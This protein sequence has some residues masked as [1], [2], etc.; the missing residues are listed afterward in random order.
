MGIE[1]RILTCVLFVLMAFS[2]QRKVHVWLIGDSTIADKEVKAYP[3]T[4]WGM[5]FAHFF[6]GE[7]VVDNRAKNGRSTG[8]FLREGLWQPVVEGLGT[9]D[10]VFIQ[11]GHNDEVKTKASYTTPEEFTGNLQRYIDDVRKKGAI[12]VLLTP[13]ARRKFDSLGLI[14]E[15]HPVYA[16]L[17][18][19]VAVRNKVV[20]ID[21]A[22]TSKAFLQQYG[23]EYSRVLFNYL[24]PGEH[25]NYPEGRKDDTHFSE[26]GA[27]KMA[28]LVAVG[29][30]GL[31]LGL[32]E[33]LV[34]V[35][36]AAGL[37]MTVAADGSGDYL[38][39]QAAL[40]AVPLNNVK[41]V[42]I[43]IRRGVYREKLRLDS[44]KN[45][46]TLLGEDEWNTIL[47][48]DDHP[49][50]RLLT[51]DSVN[52][53]NSHSFLVK[54]DDFT[55][56]RLTIRNDAGFSAGQAVALEVQGDRAR[57]EEC[58]IVGNQDVLFL[59]SARSRVCFRYCDIEGTTDFIFGDATAW[60]DHCH[61]HSK[62]DS[63]VTAA[64]TP[65]DHP[66][67]FVFYDCIL[68]GDTSIHHASL[69]R[70]WRP[71]ASVDYIRCYIGAHIRPEG[72]SDWNNN[73]SYKTAR[74][75]EYRDYGP[76]A[77]TAA[78][79]PWV[80]Q[81]TDEEAGRVGVRAV[82]GGWEPVG[83]ATAN[84]EDYSWDHLPVISEPVFR[85]DTFSIVR[86]GAVQDPLRL[87]T[88]AINDAIADC[89]RKG[90]GVV[91]V[92]A[93]YWLTGPLVLRSGVNLHIDRAA[94]LQFTADL[95]QYPLVEGNW[96]G[97]PAARCQSPIS[98]TDL[99]NIAITGGGIIDASGDAWR[100]LAKD[101]LPEGEWNKKV[102]AGGVLSEDGKTWYPS[103]KSLKG[104][105]AKDAGVLRPGMT[106]S[107]F[108]DIKDFLRPNL[109]VL[110]RCKKVLLEGTS[111]Q[112]SPAWCLHTLLCEDLTL[113]D[114]HVRNPWYAA[115]GDGV[116]L[117]SC[118]NVLVENSTFDAGD[119]GICI[120]SGRDEEGRKRGKPTENV[121][122]RNDIVYR[123][124]GG[125]V[126]GSEMS[127]GARNIFVSDC[128][129]I[130][131]DIGLR[132][133]TV[134]GRGG[135]VEKIWVRNISMR[136]IV[137]QAVFLDMYYFARAPAPGE[138]VAAAPPVTE[139]TPSFRNIHISNIV[140]D[141]AEEG[142]F[143]RGLP[144]MRI[145]DIYMENMVL[146]ADK[147]MEVS[148]GENIYLKDIK[149]I[150]KAG[151]EEINKKL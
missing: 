116:D 135:V 143:V 62:K 88:G 110:T 54:A 20:L 66:Y 115:N 105:H 25:P 26:W 11:F 69:G 28:E 127:G 83:E 140:C 17:V 49:G 68:T 114:V 122:I 141:G 150:T 86:Y 104:A 65:A 44:S 113:R 53:R 8:T 5:P 34:L 63:H 56:R 119:D 23:P 9:G 3:E 67:G 59:N 93:G 130:G 107:S 40:D 108:A 137:H 41:P 125:F 123:G 102:A 18:R 64:S 6:D 16:Q 58:R 99:E 78:R 10:Y 48:Y 90:G 35:R 7:V 55:A 151:T 27:M 121:I 100:M 96:E 128:S 38:T 80:H 89:S 148:E 82:L 75:G 29:I 98:G 2:P 81:L 146:K 19:D 73:G 149:L 139:G 131:T 103:E 45:F 51:G 136:N 97:H 70:P 87:N 39:V 15:T 74:Y 106:L 12:P 37:V 57:I 46:V 61:I 42:T 22:E 132:F 112:N 147:G 24:Q 124:H 36:P 60:F 134:R 85:Q 31:K 133:K 109:L 145:R 21:L 33:H 117:E 120:K 50:M 72:W 94:I 76:G 13:V 111:F 129:F 144:E 126:V 91:L 118:R 79:V 4:G 101:R 71:Y 14:E 84:V 47:T 142:I 43:F 77:D 30:R 138:P 95:S 1:G 92:P 32:A 52:T